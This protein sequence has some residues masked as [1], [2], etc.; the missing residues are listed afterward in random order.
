M[1]ARQGVGAQYFGRRI[2]LAILYIA[3]VGRRKES[4]RFLSC[5]TGEVVIDITGIVSAVAYHNHRMPEP[6]EL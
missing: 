6:R 4:H 5:Q 2:D 1:P 3:L